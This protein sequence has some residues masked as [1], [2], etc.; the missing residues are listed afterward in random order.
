M[1]STIICTWSTGKYTLNIIYDKNK[2]HLSSNFKYSWEGTLKD[3]IYD[4]TEEAF[5]SAIEKTGDRLYELNVA[6]KLDFHSYPGDSVYAN[7]VN[8]FIP[9]IQKFM[10]DALTDS[11]Y[12]FEEDGELRKQ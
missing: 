6:S 9:I 1:D 5:L 12:V 2:Y 4:H 11:L 10:V 3:Y 7:M 8:C